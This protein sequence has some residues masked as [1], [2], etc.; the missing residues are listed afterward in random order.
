MKPQKFASKRQNLIYDVGMHEGEDTEYYLKKG[1]M[2]I[3][4]EADPQLVEHCRDKF[5]KAIKQSEVVIVPGAIIDRGAVDDGQNKVR[6]YRNLDNSDWGTTHKAWASRNEQ[7]GSRNEV[8]EV[9]AVDF[10]PGG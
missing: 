5:T 7:L 1:F 6:F 4:F 8:I 2:V 10:E 9:D 3:G